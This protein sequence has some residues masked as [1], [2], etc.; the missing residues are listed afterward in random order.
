MAEDSTRRD[1]SCNPQIAFSLRWLLIVRWLF[2]K[3]GPLSTLPR[4][5]LPLLLVLFE[6]FQLSAHHQDFLLLQR[7]RLVER[8]HSVFLKGELALQLLQVLPD[9]VKFL[10]H[11]GRPRAFAVFVC[12]AA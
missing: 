10:C 9:V 1:Y 5:G 6:Q 8:L 12:C 7:Q 3:Q 4:A 2:I 11:G